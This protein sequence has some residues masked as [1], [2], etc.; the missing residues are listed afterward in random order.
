MHTDAQIGCI[1]LRD[2]IVSVART[3]TRHRSFRFRRRCA[4]RT[5]LDTRFGLLLQLP[6][7]RFADFS[8]LL[9]LYGDF[10]TV[11]GLHILL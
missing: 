5:T 2:L 8:A 11:H 4:R 3:F 6:C 1:I 7:S 9:R 10:V